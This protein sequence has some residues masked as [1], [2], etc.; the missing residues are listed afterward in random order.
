MKK[1]ILTLALTVILVLNFAGV[2]NAAEN[3]AK[4]NFT[5]TGF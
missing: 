1:R 3:Q 4:F 5:G 2:A